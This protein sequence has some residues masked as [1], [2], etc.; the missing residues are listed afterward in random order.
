MK[1]SVIWKRADG[2]FRLSS[3]HQASQRADTKYDMKLCNELVKTM[4]VQYVILMYVASGR[5]QLPVI[6]Y[7]MTDS[8]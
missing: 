8:R 5:M 6:A 7:T 1:S 2:I 4:A 3:F